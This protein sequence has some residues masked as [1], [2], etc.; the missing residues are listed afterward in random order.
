MFPWFSN[1]PSIVKTIIVAG[2]A[3]A[4]GL[5]FWFGLLTKAWNGVG[6]TLFHRQITA[7]R[8]KVQKEL[9]AAAEMKKALEQTL[10]EYG[11]AKKELV[12]VK[13]EKD[14]LEQIFNDKS[15]GAATKV[16]EFKKILNQSV[17]RTPTDNISTSDLCQR[18]I[19]IGASADTIKSLCQP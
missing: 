2:L 13:A 14:R 8:V 10:L 1:L 5:L 7:E 11:Q 9:D 3:I 19:A 18:S 12:T 15:I 17:T 4:L 6:N 16:A